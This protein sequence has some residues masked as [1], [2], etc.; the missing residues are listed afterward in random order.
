MLTSIPS[1]ETSFQLEISFYSIMKDPDPL[2]PTKAVCSK[3]SPTA[4]HSHG[5]IINIFP[6]IEEGFFLFKVLYR[7]DEHVHL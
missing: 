1:S 7:T 2:Y 4:V 5:D 6:V 3:P